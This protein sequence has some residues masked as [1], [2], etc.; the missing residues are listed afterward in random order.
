MLLNLSQKKRDLYNALVRERKIGLE[1]V[2]YRLN[3]DHLF[4]HVGEPFLDPLLG[5]FL[6]RKRLR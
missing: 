2:L 4:L 5:F 6:R 3:L 1:R